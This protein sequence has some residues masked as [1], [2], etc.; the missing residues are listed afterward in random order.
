MAPR[1]NARMFIHQAGNSVCV[2]LHDEVGGAESSH[3]EIGD[4][5]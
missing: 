4:A 2:I 1:R 3:A 5:W